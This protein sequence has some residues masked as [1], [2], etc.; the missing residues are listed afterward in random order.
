MLPRLQ[1]LTGVEVL[2]EVLHQTDGEVPL[3]VGGQLV[4]DEPVRA[5][6]VLDHRSGMEDIFQYQEILYNIF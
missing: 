5:G 2:L 3:V 1:F 6:A 4:E